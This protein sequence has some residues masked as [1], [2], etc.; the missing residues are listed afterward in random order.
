MD[1]Y[2]RGRDG[3][4]G[5]SG[6]RGTD[7]TGTPQA[8]RT[9]VGHIQIPGRIPMM[10][11]PPGEGEQTIYGTGSGSGLAPRS[12]R[13]AVRGGRTRRPSVHGTFSDAGSDYMPR[14][15]NVPRSGPRPMSLLNSELDLDSTP[16]RQPGR[17]PSRSASPPRA[18][19]RLRPA[20]LDDTPLGV[21]EEQPHVNQYNAG[22]IL[23]AA[24]QMLPGVRPE[25]LVIMSPDESDPTS[26]T[27]GELIEAYAERCR[28]TSDNMTVMP[29]DELQ[30]LH[31]W[32]DRLY[33]SIRGE[34]R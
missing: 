33:A 34:C 5:R 19:H 2:G 28:T 13:P 21:W 23:E 26:Y 6:G 16:R 25:S 10:V 7:R 12:Q 32:L 24:A 14:Y 15:D 20:R 22:V 8:P 27:L 17:R 30:A 1:H 31:D 3:R 9:A 4:G 18:E 11:N 29:Q